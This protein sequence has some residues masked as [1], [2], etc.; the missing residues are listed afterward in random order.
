MV[1][2]FIAAGF[3]GVIGSMWGIDDNDGPL[4]AEAFYTHLFADGR[5]PQAIDAAEALQIAVREMREKGLPCRRWAPLVHM[6]I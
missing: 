4:I 6:G 1:E 5:K 3:R 2:A